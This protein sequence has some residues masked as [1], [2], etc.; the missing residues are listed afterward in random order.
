MGY[1]TRKEE[2]PHRQSRSL[3]V[4]NGKVKRVILIWAEVLRKALCGS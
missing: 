1:K 2:P 4:A 3:V